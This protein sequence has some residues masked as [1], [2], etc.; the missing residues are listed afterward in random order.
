MPREDARTRGVRLL[1]E[2]RLVV[3]LV[4]EATVVAR[5]RG[6]HGVIHEAGFL[7]GRWHCSCPAKTTCAHLAALQ[8]VTLEPGSRILG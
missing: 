7:R 4:D 1:G 6:D 2:G 5:V 8:L 3:S